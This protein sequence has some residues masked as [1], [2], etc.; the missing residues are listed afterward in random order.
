MII[1]E[2]ADIRDIII[3]KKYTYKGHLTIRHNDSYM[4]YILAAFNNASIPLKS[5]N[6]PTNNTRLS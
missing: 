1:K 2:E 5:A 6:F 4:S 3:S